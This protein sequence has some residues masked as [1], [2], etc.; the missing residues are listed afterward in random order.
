MTAITKDDLRV[1]AAFKGEGTPVTSCYLD[2]DGSRLTRYRDVANQVERLLREGKAKAGGNVSVL[3]DLRC[4]EDYVKGG[5]DRSRT[6]GLAIFSCSA[7]EFWKVI[8][9]PVSV[10]NQMVINQSPAVRQL[11]WVLD[12]YE[13]FAVLLADR[14]YGRLVMFELGEIVE[15]R[16][17]FEQLPRGDDVMRGLARDRVQDHVDELAHQHLRHVGQVAFEALKDQP[18]ARLILAVADD[19]ASELEQLLHPYLRERLEARCVLAMNASLDEI[20]IAALAVEETIERRKESELVDRLRQAVGSGNRGVVGLVPTLEA[21]AKRSA[22]TLLISDAYEVEGWRCDSCNM[23]AAVGR[24]CALCDAD[25][26][27]V[28]DVVEEAIEE[29]LLQSCRVEIC[30]G[31]AD[32]DVLGGIGALL[33][34]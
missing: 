14:Q 2:V 12:E 26:H 10:H 1:L 6:R 30:V 17:L 4:I 3:D 9:L 15:V 21:L 19:V 22:E 16:E 11:E 24:S 33:R 7:K 13:P 20:R 32:L 25:M 5:L 29:A 27:R 8:E 31:N 34:Y 28:E 18:I 23:V